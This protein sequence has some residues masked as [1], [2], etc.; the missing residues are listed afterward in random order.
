MSILKVIISVPE[1][2]VGMVQ[3]CFG[4]ALVSPQRGALVQ[5]LSWGALLLPMGGGLLL[6]PLG[7]GGG[8]ELVHP[9]W[10]YSLLHFI[11]KTEQQ[12]GS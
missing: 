12:T 5:Y 9:C 7:G 8:G 1:N 3:G 6:Y 11:N 2:L 4:G 10:I